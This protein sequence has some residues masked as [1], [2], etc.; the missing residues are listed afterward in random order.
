MTLKGRTYTTTPTPPGSIPAI[1]PPGVKPRSAVSPPSATFAPQP[2][3]LMGKAGQ[4][5]GI[6]LLDHVHPG[7]RQILAGS[8]V[9]I[10]GPA[11]TPTIAASGSGSPNQW[12]GFAVDQTYNSG[13]FVIWDGTTSH[14]TSTTWIAG[15]Q[16][17]G[18]YDSP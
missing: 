11:D 14:A 5:P 1:T 18:A 15:I 3:G 6:S 16:Q 4:G 2:V 9:S 12:I 8:G 13:P 17:G 10:T 7:V